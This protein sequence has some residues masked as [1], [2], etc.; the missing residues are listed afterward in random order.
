MFSR[1]HRAVARYLAEEVK[2]RGVS[3]DEVTSSLTMAEVVDIVDRATPG[4]DL[5]KWGMVPRAQL[6]DQPRSGI[7]EIDAAVAAA[8]RGEWLPAAELMAGSYGDWD[9]RATAVN[10]LAELAADD[11]GWLTAWR[12]ARPDDQHVAPVDCA[13]L[14]ILAWK[15]RGSGRA[16]DVTS[17]RAEHFHRVL[18]RAE[19]VA[20][21]ATEALPGDPTP[22]ATLAAIARGRSYDHAA[23]DRVW[24]GVVERAPLHRYGHTMALQYWTAKWC[25]S[26]ERMW[27]FAQE[28]A[29]KSPSLAV[30][31]LQ[32]AWEEGWGRPTTRDALETHLRWLATDGAT[33]V[34]LLND[35]G[36]AAYGL[37]KVGRK[38]EAVPYFRRLGDY[39]GGAPWSLM[40]RPT[41][42]FNESRVKACKAAGN[43]YTV[44]TG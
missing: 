26:A 29:A 33:G 43:S 3:V 31:M 2:R 21:A 44:P 7:A 6:T 34:H 8:R 1:R 11:D 42:F 20:L 38:A 5:S 16:K 30:V 41:Y 4:R 15:L 27:E 28:A 14:T 37:A 18:A 9:Y 12:T 19:V 36:W 24:Q 10:L 32:A 22:W 23:F 13:A 17:E 39:A 35:L 25:G 40:A